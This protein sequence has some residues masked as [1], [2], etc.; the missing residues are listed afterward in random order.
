MGGLGGGPKVLRRQKKW[1]RS[2]KTHDIINFKIQRNKGFRSK[3][4]ILAIPGGLGLSRRK[5]SLWKLDVFERKRGKR[6]DRKG[7]FRLKGGSTLRGQILA[8]K[9]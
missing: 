4:K 6:E 3:R 9:R 1:T 5:V 8:G 7:K 2:Q